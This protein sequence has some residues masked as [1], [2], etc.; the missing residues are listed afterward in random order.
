MTTTA[1]THTAEGPGAQDGAGRPL[2]AREG[3]FVFIVSIGMLFAAG[4]AVYVAARTGAGDHIVHDPYA[5]TRIALPP[6]LWVS[7]FFLFVSSVA[8]YQGR[9]WI[10][11]GRPVGG[12]RGVRA[13]MLT[14]GLFAV[15]QVP[16]LVAL[17][18]RFRPAGGKPSPVYFLVI[19]LVALHALHALG[20]LAAGTALT[21]RLDPAS[22][23][24]SDRERLAVFALYWHFVVAAWLVLFATFCL[25]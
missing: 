2:F 4:I 8:L 25:V 12:L 22:L 14:G 1:A 11:M 5:G 19:A 24:A 13:A 17:V 6:W 18:A 10:A 20:G 3:V 23:S 9:Q 7:T 15:L 21:R 16:G